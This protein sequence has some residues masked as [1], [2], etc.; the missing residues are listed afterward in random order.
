ML[1][2]GNRLA[3]HWLITHKH[4]FA[5]HLGVKC[6]TETKGAEEAVGVSVLLV[7]LQHVNIVQGCFWNLSF[8]TKS[9]KQL[10]AIVI[11]YS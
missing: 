11:I 9:T 8:W 10:I 6:S 2:Q 5:R 4:F 7:L 3:A 1:L